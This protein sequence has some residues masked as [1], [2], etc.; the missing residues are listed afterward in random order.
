MNR[1][2]EQ[3]L[4]IRIMMKRDV[5]LTG[6]P[7]MKLL[8][9]DHLKLFT[10]PIFLLYSSNRIQNGSA[11]ALLAGPPNNFFDADVFLPLLASFFD[12][13]LSRRCL[14]SVIS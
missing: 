1:S 9:I 6:L 5:S 2:Q 8:M 3:I 10:T 14:D 11:S 4:L 12:N 7:K 13:L